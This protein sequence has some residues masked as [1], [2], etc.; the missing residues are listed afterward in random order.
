VLPRDASIGRAEKNRRV[1]ARA[2]GQSFTQ[3]ENWG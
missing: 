1:L 2:A 3:E